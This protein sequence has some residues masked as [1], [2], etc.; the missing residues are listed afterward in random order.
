MSRR[1]LSKPRSKG[2]RP[3]RSATGPGLGAS[4]GLRIGKRG[5]YLISGDRKVRSFRVVDWEQFVQT[6]DS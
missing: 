6:L 5:I 3:R 4:T 1:G 2:K